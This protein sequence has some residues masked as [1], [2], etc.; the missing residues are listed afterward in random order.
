M[1]YRILGPL[2]VLADGSPIAL[3]PEKER[4]LLGVLLLRAN[5]VVSAEDLIDELWGDTPPASAAKLVQVYVS[6]LRKRLDG[7]GELLT[8]PPGYLL[9]ADDDE[10]DAVRFEQLVT[11]ARR[12][13]RSGANEEA[14]ERFELALALWR[15]PVLADVT[16][17]SATAGDVERLEELRLV[18]LAERIDCRLALGEHERLVAELDPLVRAHPFRERFR[19]QQMLA[20]Y[21]SGRQA[22]ALAAYQEGRRRLVDELG[23]EP[24]SELQELERS[25]LRQDPVLDPPK[26]PAV[27]VAGSRPRLYWLAAG[28]AMAGIAAGVLALLVRGDDTGIAL[29]PRTVGRIDA[30]ANAVV[31]E[32]ALGSRPTALTADGRAL[33]AGAREGTVTRVDPRRGRIAATVALGA[34]PSS[35]VLGGGSLW[36]GDG[37]HNEV[38]Q[39]DPVRAAVS[40]RI[41]LPTP[42]ARAAILGA[43]AP[44]LAFGAGSLWVSSGQEVVRRVDPRTRATVATTRPPGGA[45]QAIAYGAGAVWVGG[46]NAL[47]RISPSTGRA[48]S[49]IRLDGTPV[50]LAVGA[51]AVWAALGD[52]GKVARVDV[53]TEAVEAISLGAAATALVAGADAV[54]AA[55]PSLGAVVRIDPER[56]EVVQTI[57]TGATP[58]SLA[59][60]GEAPWVAV[61]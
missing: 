59:L 12:L 27:A 58:V 42:S 33:W 51:G 39:I 14:A 54:W 53:E 44:S 31:E 46:P 48:T 4:V 9:A 7:S 45:N 30:A 20:L 19:A 11:D 1:E 15:G 60:V 43:V 16:L 49:T 22:D 2:E 21:R 57:E 17:E 8:R 56:N 47:T 34:P 13:A 18:A 50:A 3:G 52:G 41:R 10:L 38:I 40:H 24:G 29:E 61:R 36:A 55:A 23:L 37:I 35:L 5:R 26:R 6:Q 32:V 25:I 28:V